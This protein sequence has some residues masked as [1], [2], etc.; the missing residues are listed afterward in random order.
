MET[1]EMIEW[2]RNLAK[3]TDH[4]IAEGFSRVAD[5][6]ER[7]SRTDGDLISRKEFE[8]ALFMVGR[9]YVGGLA[10]ENRYLQEQRVYELLREAP[11]VEAEPI[12]HAR[13][14]IERWSSGYIKRC[15]CSNCGNHPKD[16][17]APPKFCDNCGAH[18][19]EPIKTCYCPVCDKHFRIRSNESSGSCP[20]CGHHVVLCEEESE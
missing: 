13:W 1:T 15:N 19:D 5:R 3:H 10:D 16:A 4:P 8:K 11:S 12:R 6:L 2:L 18:M 7:L 17:Y 14:V 9:M 20:D